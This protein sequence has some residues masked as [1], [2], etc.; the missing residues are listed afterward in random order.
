MSFRKLYHYFG[1][2]QYL[3][4][5]FHMIILT[6][7]AADDIQN[8]FGGVRRRGQF[9]VSDGLSGK[10]LSNRDFLKKKF[11]PDEERGLEDFTK[12]LYNVDLLNS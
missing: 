1:L 3:D 4:K 10:S 6:E 8:F 5:I 11:V 2:Q 12:I 7:M 9:P